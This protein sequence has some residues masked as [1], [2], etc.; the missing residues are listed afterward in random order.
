VHGKKVAYLGELHPKV[1]S[2]FELNV[3]VV[4]LEL[5]LTDLFEVINKK[6]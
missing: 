5:N 4:G 3:P 1:I 6:P 2:N